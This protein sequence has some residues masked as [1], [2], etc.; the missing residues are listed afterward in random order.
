MHGADVLGD[1]L[2][3]FAVATRGRMSKHAVFVAQVD[4]KA[5]EL[6]LG[7]VLDRRI[8]VIQSS[9]LRTLASKARAPLASVSVSVRIDSIG[10]A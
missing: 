3:G 6:Q 4:G 2:A 1:V 9:S 5:V 7:G 10:T 8:G